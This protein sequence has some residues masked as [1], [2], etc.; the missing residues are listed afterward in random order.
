MSLV[1]CPT[2]TVGATA[3]L[4]HDPV[5]ETPHFDWLVELAPPAPAVPTFRL[6]HRLDLAAAGCRLEAVRIAD[7]RRLYLT[8]D[9]PR[10]L[11]GERGRVTPFRRG[12]AAI[13]R[14]ERDG[15]GLAID[16]ADPDE[17]GASVRTELRL[18]SA[19]GSRWRI[20]VLAR[21]FRPALPNTTP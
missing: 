8:L 3:L 2:P 19:G 16:W 4:R 18:E 13:V 20:E 10:Q 21:E 15:Y 5:G 9:E 17:S 14:G 6:G 12:V 1:S 11:S 7:H